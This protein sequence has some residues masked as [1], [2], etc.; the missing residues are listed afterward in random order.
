[1]KSLQESLFDDNIKSN[2]VS[3][4]GVSIDADTWHMAGRLYKAIRKWVIKPGTKSITCT[5]PMQS[6]YNVVYNEDDC[7]ILVS[8]QSKQS[9]LMSTDGCEM[10]MTIVSP[11]TIYMK[12]D[13]IN[14]P[15]DITIADTVLKFDIFEGFKK[16][17]RSGFTGNE[18]FP[19]VISDKA[20]KIIEK[21]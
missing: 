16:F 14:T 9:K 3:I 20:R 4:H 2:N 8:K 1:M 6:E 21:F 15:I 13:E 5:N 18:Y 10:R 17:I 19:E 12:Y 11:E 7:I